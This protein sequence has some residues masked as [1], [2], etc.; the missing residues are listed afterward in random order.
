M[1]EANHQ[2]DNLDPSG[3][4]RRR[5]EG[6]EGICNSIGR[7][8][9]LNQPDPLKLPG[10]KP[11]TKEHTPMAPAAYVAEDGLSGINGL[12]SPW[13]CGVSMPQCRRMLGP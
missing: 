7:K 3:G 9:I 12:G 10:T 2:T 1:L 5:T 13:S 11:P 4:V 8:T 6:A